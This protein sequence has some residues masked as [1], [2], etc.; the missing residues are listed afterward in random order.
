MVPRLATPLNLVVLAF[1]VIAPLV[2][3]TNEVAD[4]N[5]TLVSAPPATNA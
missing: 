3:A 4:W 2:S 1:G 5:Q